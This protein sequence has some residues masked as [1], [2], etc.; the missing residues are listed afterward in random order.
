MELKH[1][2]LDHDIDRAK[3]TDYEKAVERVMAMDEAELL[4]FVPEYGFASCC[5]CP[6]CYGGVQGNGVFSWSIDRPDELR[7]RYCGAVPYPNQDYVE[8]HDLVGQNV[9]GE[10]IRLP[11]Y[12]NADRN[13]PHFFSMHLQQYRR[14]WLLEQCIALGKAYQV[15]GNEAYARLPVLI[16][17][18]LAQVY[19]HYPAL[20]NRSSRR[21]S[22]CES[23]DPPYSW[24]AGRWGYFHNE[25]PKPV[26]AI[27][28]LVYHSPE[29]D[30]LSTERGYDVREKLVDGFFRQTYEIAAASTFH[31]GN[32]VGYDVA[33]VAM[34][35]RVIGE[36]AYV[37]Q[38]FGWM[39]QN[40]DE[41]FFADGLW[42]EAP[43]YHYMTVG[44]L[45]QAFD[46]VRGYSDPPDYVDAIDGTRLDETDPEREL[47]FWKAVQRAPEVLDF[48]NGLSTPVHDT[49]AGDKRSEPRSRTEST[50]A[51]AY[52]HASLG[53]GK[54]EDQMQAQLH[55]SGTHGHHH[56][57]N[58]GLTL[59][60][61]GSEMLS[62]LGY[63]WT[64]MRTW[65]NSTLGHNTV[66]IDRTSQNGGTSDGD[67][68]WFFP[69]NQGVSVVEADGRRAY[70]DIAEVDQYRR[71]LVMIPVS[72]SGAYI[73]DIFRV[74]GGRTHD[75]AL[76]G[77][78]DTDMSAACDLELD[79]QRKWML[80]E[81][82]A[83]DEPTIIGS[84]FNPYGMVRD[85][86]KGTPDGISHVEFT[87]DE[88]PARGIR[89]HIAS[90]GQTAGAAEEE[91]WLGQAPSV[92]RMGR[93]T[94]ADMRTAYDFWMPQMV[95]RRQSDA[96]IASTFAAV[97]E[98]FCGD[99]FIK[100]VELLNLEPAGS[101]G[102]ALQVTHSG[103]TDTIITTLDES[104]Y[105]QRITATG[106]RMKGRLG[107]VRQVEGKPTAGWLFEGDEL[108]ADG[109][110]L[111]LST[112]RHTGRI[113]EAT[114]KADG[115]DHDAF[116]V[117]AD[118]PEGSGLHGVWMIVTHGN[119]FTHGYEIDRV[120]THE[121]RKLV[122]LAHD[123]A[124]R[125]TGE[126]TEEVYFPQR[127]IEGPNTFV[128]PLAS[129]RSV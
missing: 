95:M 7:C 124:L 116:I 58:L 103:G 44:G 86:R 48:P 47:P 42:H 37:H 123:H 50:I 82:E 29:F 128:I 45:R 77:D 4:S 85:V 79:D 98:P 34:L 30:R 20:H 33:G 122:I 114:R 112:N 126:T 73:V 64:Q 111:A 38:A 99:R 68:V 18:R 94:N 115:S 93:G 57:D 97:H 6:S 78:A 41:G 60:A 5:E 1:P 96:P 113:L 65:C 75:W 118:L 12:L 108:E 80:E 70:T 19:P 125:I 32:V 27:Y 17:D 92:R 104:P 83:W 120:Q 46:T 69:D 74:S 40:V 16:L 15:T 76:H 106:I 129:S 21:V 67:L 72:E 81:G 91:L 84:V 10:E 107:V 55:F 49:W 105:P 61:K 28:D 53:R 3:A 24:D 66:V 101:H 52:G 13:I 56:F 100:R 25:I 89:T 31:V 121:G 26:I 62:D 59:F 8:A 54:N 109:L 87:Y 23:Q 2:I 51:P 9:L 39:K 90:V 63:T 102:V 71:M 43:S 36:P 35:G 117:D 11:Y 110:A 127:K 22:F 119:G 14:G 88:E